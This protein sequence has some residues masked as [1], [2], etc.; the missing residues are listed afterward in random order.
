MNDAVTTNEE[1]QINIAVMS[2]DDLP[3]TG[4][5]NIQST[6]PPSN[7][8]ITVLPDGTIDYTPNS[9]FFGTD[10]FTY[11]LADASG[12][13]STATVTVTVV[14]VQDPPVA[15]SSSGNTPEDTTLPNIAVL[16]NDSD[17]DGDMLT[18][19][20]ATA[21]NGTV[22]INPDGTVDYT[23]NPGFNGTDTISY[24]ISDGNGGT[25]SSTVLINVAPVADP[26]TSADNTVTTDEEVPYAFT[27]N[28]FAFADQDPS[29]SLVAVRIDTLP[30]VGQL[31]LNGNPVTAGQVVSLSDITNGNLLF[32]PAP[33]DFGNNYTTFDFSVTDG[34]LFQT[35]SN[36]MTINV[37]PIQDPPIAT[38]NA[39]TVA[40]DS[41][42]SQLGLAPPTD[43]DGDTLTATVTGLPSVGTVFLADGVTPVNNG[44]TLTVAQLTSL[45]F[46]APTTFTTANA[47]SFTYDVSDGN[48]IDSG[49]VEI[50]ITP[51]NDPPA[52]C[53]GGHTGGS[54]QTFI[55]D[56]AGLTRRRVSS[57]SSHWSHYRRQSKR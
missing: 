7:G 6:T 31:L 4:A 18:V 3:T 26:P 48:A 14:N 1:T 54:A 28:D 27:A 36:T 21:P 45:I 34:V 46:D 25:A 43:V 52:V 44:D 12:R 32:V 35:A 19:T 5:F 30:A 9:N 37:N 49:E 41:T 56:R 11:T 40:E 38:D 57:R 53:I 22:V 47:G 51:V 16:A 17:P 39:I 2:N 13:T 8:S 24:S 10:I 15:N 50:T 29:D 33:N 42:G 23:P 20:T 55:D